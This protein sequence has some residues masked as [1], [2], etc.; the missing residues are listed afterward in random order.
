MD[1][2][3]RTVNEFPPTPADSYPRPQH[4]PWRMS[5]W[6]L[7]A[8][9]LSVAVWFVAPLQLRVSLH[10]LSLIALAA[11]AGYWLD[12]SLFPYARPDAFLQLGALEDELPPRPDWAPPSDCETLE[13]WAKPDEPLLRLMGACMLRRAI[14]VA[15]TMLALGLGA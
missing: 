4:L 5:G 10:K 6:L 7:I 8:L 3:E 15:A 13:V 14:I 9:L 1:P 11:V 2:K 12:R